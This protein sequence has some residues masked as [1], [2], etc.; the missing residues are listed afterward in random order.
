[1]APFERPRSPA[2]EEVPHA[3]CHRLRSNF[4]VF[5]HALHQLEIR[6]SRK[7]VIIA[8]SAPI[9][10]VR[11]GNVCLLH[12]LHVSSTHTEIGA[13]RTHTSGFGTSLVGIID[14]NQADTRTE[15]RGNTVSVEYQLGQF[16]FFAF[17]N[18]LSYQFFSRGRLVYSRNQRR[19][20]HNPN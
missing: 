12:F 9:K 19:Q 16:Y 2:S 3:T 14:A 15:L 11:E 6:S 13:R 1:M 20:P 4:I 18:F 10:S 8:Q 17:S 5:L 7:H